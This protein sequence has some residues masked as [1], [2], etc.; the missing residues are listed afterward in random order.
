MRKYADIPE[1]DVRAFAQKYDQFLIKNARMQAN[2]ITGK[3]L[4]KRLRKMGVHT[5]T[6][7]DGWC[8]SDVLLLPVCLLDMLADILHLVE[9]TGCWPSVFATGYVSLIPKGEGMLPMQQRPLS[10]LSQIYRVW[11][12]IRLEEYMLW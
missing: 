4:A 11:A 8:V 7:L 3:R 10:V 1:P 12:G 9:Q 5:A 2:P 6:G